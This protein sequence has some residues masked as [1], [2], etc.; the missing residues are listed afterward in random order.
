MDRTGTDHNRTLTEPV[1]TE[2][3]GGEGL[4]IWKT[5]CLNFRQTV[6]GAEKIWAI[7]FFLAASYEKF[8]HTDRSHRKN[9]LCP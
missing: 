9:Q 3:R 1:S 5:G 8:A 6:T 7:P 4:E 2:L